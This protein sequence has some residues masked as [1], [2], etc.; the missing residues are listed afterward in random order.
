MLSKEDKILIT[1][2]YN[3]KRDLVRRDRLQSSPTNIGHSHCEASAA[4]DRQHHNGQ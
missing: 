1:K 3:E 2:Y 4:E